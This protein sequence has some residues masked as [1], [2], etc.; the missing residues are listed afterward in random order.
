[1]NYDILKKLIEINTVQDK[2]NKIFVSYISE[3]L[4]N[5][6]FKVEY[7][8]GKSDN[9]C[10][11]AKTKDVC[12]L[13]FLGHSDT[14]P[15]KDD[16]ETNPFKLTIKDGFM[17]VR[18][19]CDMKGGI[20]AFLDALSAIDINNINGLMIIIT[21]DEEIG[22]EGINLVKNKEDIPEN[23]IIGEPTDLVP[24][25]FCKGCM[26]FK[27]T[28]EG[29]SVHSSLA[30]S[31][32]NA[33]LKMY[34]YINEI[35]KIETNLKNSLNDKYTIPYTTLNISTI[36]GGNA[37]NIVPDSCSVTFDFRT[38]LKSHH[39]YIMSEINEITNKYNGKL[40]VITNVLPSNNVTEDVTLF[41]KLTG[42]KSSGM[43]YVT[44]GNFLDKDNVIILGPGPITPHEKNEHISVESYE[45]L[46]E[47]YRKI[48][49][50]YCDK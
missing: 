34:N 9:K 12:N 15:V 46:K 24:I 26:E 3:H 8:C 10:L 13:C 16:W 30:P 4:T 37:I 40:E 42:K 5:L 25:T 45:K 36:N 28:I 35:K 19:V 39:E 44:E 33:I 1:M 7:V 23:I 11:V 21:Y 41:E 31:G 22:F 38:N 6:G 17:Y 50:K 18:G 27:V 32:D 2:D 47:I 14:V 43:D 49:L 20:A 48:I 29:K